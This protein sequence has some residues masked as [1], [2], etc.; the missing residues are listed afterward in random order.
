MFQVYNSRPGEGWTIYS[1]ITKAPNPPDETLTAKIGEL[2]TNTMN[3]E[4]TERLH[5]FLYK[6]KTDARERHKEGQRT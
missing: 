2:T 4:A 5:N 3:K 1:D 6:A